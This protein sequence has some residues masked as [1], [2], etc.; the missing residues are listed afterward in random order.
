MNRTTNLCLIMLLFL[1]C[2]QVDKKSYNIDSVAS[3][4]GTEVFQPNWENIAKNYKFPQWF[5]DGKFGIFIHWGIYA[6]PA[7]DNEWYARNMYQK[8][9]KAYNHH[10]ETWGAHD[11][12]G[13]KDF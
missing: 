1:S 5:T 6:V 9:S 4:K 2:Q 11:K 13:Y 10:I 8:D 3:P 7:F 12:F